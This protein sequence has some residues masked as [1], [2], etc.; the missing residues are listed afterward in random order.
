MPPAQPDDTYLMNILTKQRYIL[1]V[2][3]AKI[4]HVNKLRPK[5]WRPSRRAES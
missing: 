1:F 4:L 2:L 3:R 5:F